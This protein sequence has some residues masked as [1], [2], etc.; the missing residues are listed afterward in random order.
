MLR[1][2]G[3]HLWTNV[4]IQETDVF[5]VWGLPQLGNTPF[6]LQELKGK[7]HNV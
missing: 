4:L 5:I 6:P 1:F 2:A 3:S 7:K